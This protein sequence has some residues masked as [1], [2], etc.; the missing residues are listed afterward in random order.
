MIGDLGLTHEEIAALQL[1][2]GMQNF[3]ILS[4]ENVEHEL[5]LFSSKFRW[6]RSSEETD[7]GYESG[8]SEEDEADDETDIVQQ[9]GEKEEAR[10]RML[11]NYKNKKISMSRRKA[12]D[13]KEKKDIETNMKI[14]KTKFWY[15]IR[16]EE[17]DS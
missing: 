16:L 11:G 15:Q 17:T 5:A 10:S 3:V 13:L 2:P 8:N 6:A 7:E 12:T 4:E 9:L 1:P 14:L